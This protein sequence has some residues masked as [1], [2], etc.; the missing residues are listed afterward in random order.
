MT[1]RVSSNQSFQ[2][3]ISVKTAQLLVDEYMGY[4]V[5]AP[6]PVVVRRETYPPW[7]LKYANF[8]DTIIKISAGGEDWGQT[9]RRLIVQMIFYLHC[10]LQQPNPPLNAGLI[11]NAIEPYFIKQSML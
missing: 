10:T 3:S 11:V 4:R 5:V 1:E 9:Y 8:S 7:K 2:R 6:I